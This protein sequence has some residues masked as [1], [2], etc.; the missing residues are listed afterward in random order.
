MFSRRIIHWD[1]SRPPLNGFLFFLSGSPR[2]LPPVLTLV[3][4]VDLRQVVVVVTTV[5]GPLS[6]PLPASLP[7]QLVRA[8]LLPLGSAVA[9]QVTRQDTG[10]YL[11]ANGTWQTQ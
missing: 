5:L 1:P 7:G 9:V 11:N 10:Q 4:P 2:S 3:L 8:P 6:R